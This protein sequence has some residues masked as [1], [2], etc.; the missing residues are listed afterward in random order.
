L[1]IQFILINLRIKTYPLFG[2]Y[3][4]IL[5]IS[6]VILFEIM[7]GYIMIPC[8]WNDNEN[9]SYLDSSFTL[10]YQCKEMKNKSVFSFILSVLLISISLIGIFEIELTTVVTILSIG[11]A[12]GLFISLY[13]GYFMPSKWLF[14]NRFWISGLFAGVGLFV[15]SI[16]IDFTD[17]QLS[18]SNQLLLK[19]ILSLVIGIALVGG[20]QRRRYLKV[21]D[22]THFTK[23]VGEREIMD[24][25][26]SMY[27]RNKVKKGRIILTSSR[28][29]F[30]KSSDVKVFTFNFS[31]MALGFENI[32]F[33]GIPTGI[34]IPEKVTKIYVHFSNYWIREITKIV[35]EQS[36]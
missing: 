10:F 4:S 12:Y 34:F 11:I 14:R 7:L 24:D 15:L 5:S 18:E 19:F 32:K 17:I 31:E 2:L 20:Y 27:I 25:V 29:V 35:N 33:I 36:I 16:F 9:Q 28:L 3:N 21:K 1:V 22:N 6:Q 26:A 13:K 8:F 23:H 30:V